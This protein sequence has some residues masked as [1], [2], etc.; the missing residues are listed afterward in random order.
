MKNM[1]VETTLFVLKTN[2]HPVRSMFIHV[3]LPTAHI[4][5]LL[6]VVQILRIVQAVVSLRPRAELGWGGGPH[7]L[8]QGA[9]PD[10]GLD[11]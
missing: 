11:G 2:S 8:K 10:R 3:P 9:S 7:P 5:P 6:F 1:Q 4:R